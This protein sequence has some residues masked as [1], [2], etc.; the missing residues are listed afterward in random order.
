MPR[1]FE[2]IL[3]PLQTELYDVD[4]AFFTLLLKMITD[5]PDCPKVLFDQDMSQVGE[6]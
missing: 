2:N 4:Y 3:E 6:L 1:T 5:W